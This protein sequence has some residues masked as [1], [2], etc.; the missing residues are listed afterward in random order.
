MILS[1]IHGWHMI[2][3]IALMVVVVLWP[4]LKKWFKDR[5]GRKLQ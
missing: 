3:V 2:G 5:F 1:I 4:D